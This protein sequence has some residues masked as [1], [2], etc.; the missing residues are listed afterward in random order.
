M[1]ICRR[2]SSEESVRERQ[3]V[4]ALASMKEPSLLQFYI[5]RE[6]LN[7]FNTFAEP[8]PI[9]NHTFLCQ[10][11]GMCLKDAPCQRARP[12]SKIFFIF[13]RRDPS[14]QIP[15]HRWPGCDRSP[16]RVGV[17]L[18]QVIGVPV[19]SALL[20]F[21]GWFDYFP[22]CA[23][24]FGGGPAVN[25]LYMCAICQVEIEALAKRRKM[26]IDTFIKV[27]PCSLQE[28]C[29]PCVVLHE[30]RISLLSRP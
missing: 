24:R 14:Q 26:E 30:K 20:A 29:P 6:W 2:K 25:H 17:P 28:R 19:P 4:V 5:S 10:H 7:K 11:G 15:L 12:N 22:S 1:Q 3:K 9:S 8:G 21:V 23:D 27:G 16:E 13:L 18:Q